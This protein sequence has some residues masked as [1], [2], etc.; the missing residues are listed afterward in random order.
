MPD[1]IFLLYVYLLDPAYIQN[2]TL[3]R[4]IE[5]CVWFVRRD[6]GYDEPFLVGCVK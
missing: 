3:E 4:V 6:M 2:E 1:Y 5:A